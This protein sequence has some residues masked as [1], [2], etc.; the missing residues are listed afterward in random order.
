MSNSTAP[1]ESVLTVRAPVVTALELKS[2]RELFARFWFW[3]LP[4]ANVSFTS[5]LPAAPATK[6][7]ASATTPERAAHR[8]RVLKA[9]I[10]NVLVRRFFGPDFAPAVGDDRVTS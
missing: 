6:G 2:C 1:T 8:M 4:S 9:F 3:L 7:M 5:A 10:V